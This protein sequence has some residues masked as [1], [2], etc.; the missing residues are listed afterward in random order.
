MYVVGAQKNRLIENNHNFTPK[1]FGWSQPMYAYTISTVIPRA[2]PFIP[3]W[4][5]NTITTT[6]SQDYH[7]L[8]SNVGLFCVELSFENA[9]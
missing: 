2:G 7:T 6:L 8:L 3:L 5:T 1:F 9:V 4:F